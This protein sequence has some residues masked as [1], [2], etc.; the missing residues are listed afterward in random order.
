MTIVKQE[1]VTNTIE[2]QATYVVF[3]EYL[4][5]ER[6]STTNNDQQQ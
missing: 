4:L 3:F 2:E 1:S 5:V 6:A